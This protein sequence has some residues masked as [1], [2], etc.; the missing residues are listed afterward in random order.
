MY[1]KEL[2]LYVPRGLP[3]REDEEPEEWERS[4][5]SPVF[6]S[7]NV[8]W[9]STCPHCKVSYSPIVYA[10]RRRVTAHHF[11]EDICAGGIYFSSGLSAN[12]DKPVWFPSGGFN[13]AVVLEVVECS[14]PYKLSNVLASEWV[15][16]GGF[17]EL[18]N[19]SSALVVQKQGLVVPGYGTPFP[20]DIQVIDG[21]V[22]FSLKSREQRQDEL[23]YHG[24]MKNPGDAG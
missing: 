20:Y 16:L 8:R 22:F 7:S 23:F 12:A 1:L 5:E 15:V 11:H 21:E 19:Q 10:S 3:P 24:A 4:L 6:V 2:A 9:P 14:P 18:D 17:P 13:T